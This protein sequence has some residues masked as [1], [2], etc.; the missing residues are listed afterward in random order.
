MIVILNRRRLIDPKR[1]GGLSGSCGQLVL[2]TSHLTVFAFLARAQTHLTEP[3][4]TSSQTAASAA[5]STRAPARIRS[6]SH[7]TPTPTTT[8]T[9]TPSRG[10]LGSK[11]R[12][13]SGRAR[14]CGATCGQLWWHNSRALVVVVCHLTIGRVA[15]NVRIRTSKIFRILLTQD[16][17]SN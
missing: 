9:T 15:N 14:R 6:T 3:T 8:P 17:I 7:R 5:A 11:S 13:F 1:C 16:K 2:F 10:Q 12:E 4:R